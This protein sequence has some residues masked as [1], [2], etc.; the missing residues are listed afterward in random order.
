MMNGEI[1][2][3]R[4][5]F[6]LRCIT[7]RAE[8]RG[9]LFRNSD[10][11]IRNSHRAFTLLELLVVIGLLV[12]LAGLVVP[13]F[14]GALERSQLPESAEQFRALIA[15]TRAQAMLDGLR[16]RIR[17]LNPDEPAAEGLN[18]A[19]LNQPIVEV[20]RDPLA[21]PEEYTP[22]LAAWAQSAS[23]LGD[24]WCFRIRIGEP[25][26]E[27]VKADLQDQELETEDEER[28]RAEMALTDDQDW[29]L[30]LQPDG[31]A[32]WMTFRLIDAE[33]AEFKDEELL[34][35]PQVDVIVDGRTGMVFLQ[36]PL[37]DDELEI[38]LDKGHSPV[39]RR[40]FM[41]SRELTDDDV[42]EIDMR[43]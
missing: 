24:V 7:G 2:N 29:A 14:R 19:E 6:S 5:V 36:R 18:E 12:L 8:V 3:F 38:L 40:D 20:E 37:S 13:S 4:T 39:L 21:A 27:T 28:L 10:F 43:R 34:D 22:V 9:S 23:F 11:A 17:F 16:Y 41:V 25:T 33:R 42:L 35:H 26:V 15:M 30:V 1:R 32:P 31:S